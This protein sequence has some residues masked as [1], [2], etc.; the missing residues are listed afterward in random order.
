MHKGAPRHFHL[1]QCDVRWNRM[2]NITQNSPAQ[3]P[4]LIPWQS[5]SFTFFIIFITAH[6]HKHIISLF[7]GL[8]YPVK[9]PSFLVRVTL[10]QPRKRISKP[11]M[12]KKKSW[13]LRVELCLPKKTCEVLTNPSISECDLI[14]KQGSCRGNK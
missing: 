6:F 10:G 5:C 8:L 9:L 1:L 13:M 3:R 4:S 12:L 11:T 7:E 2:Y 14:W